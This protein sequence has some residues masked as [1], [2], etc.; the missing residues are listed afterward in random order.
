[1]V[2]D[3]IIF[4]NFVTFLC[5]CFQVKL[6]YHDGT[7]V[8]DMNNPVTVR[9]GYTFDHNAYTEEKHKL[10]K[11]GMVTLNFYPPLENQTI[12][13]MEVSKTRHIVCYMSIELFLNN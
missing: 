5:V 12:L 4:K 2:G 13:W 10:S 6:T 1:M 8:Q 11:D 3:S 7:P 9:Y